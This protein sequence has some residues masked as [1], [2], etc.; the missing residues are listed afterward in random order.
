MRHR[1]LLRPFLRLFVLLQSG[2]PPPRP[3]PN[4]SRSLFPAAGR[5]RREQK[6]DRPQLHFRCAYLVLIL[7]IFCSKYWCVCER[8]R[9]DRGAV[10]TAARVHRLRRSSGTHRDVNNKIS[11]GAGVIG[12]TRTTFVSPAPSSKWNNCYHHNAILH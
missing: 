5:N 8:L 12:A 10:W 4:A 6:S 9:I 2:H 11:R 1:Q 3:S 7:R